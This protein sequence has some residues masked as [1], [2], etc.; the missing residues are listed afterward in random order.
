[1]NHPGHS[2]SL[3]DIIEW[4]RNMI[5]DKL[6]KDK[7][8][9]FKQV[10][11]TFW[12]CCQKLI[13]LK[14]WS[15]CLV[16][17]NV[18]PHLRQDIVWFW[19]YHTLYKTHDNVDKRTDNVDVVLI[20]KTSWPVWMFAWLNSSSV[21]TWF[22]EHNVLSCFCLRST[23]MFVYVQKDNLL[24]KWNKNDY[25]W[26]FYVFQFLGF[27]NFLIFLLFFSRHFMMFLDY[28][29]TFNEFF[30]IFSGLYNVFGI[31]SRHFLNVFVLFQDFIWFFVDF[32]WMILP[33]VSSK[34]RNMT[35]G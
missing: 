26:N 28:F 33:P 5:K 21:D 7:T 23:Q 12:S 1:M 25:F 11:Q 20:D 30:W 18:V 16:S 9:K 35:N 4:H 15:C 8:C 22:V 10:K 3:N 17:G 19:V 27:L 29:R 24:M 34:A 31:I 14:G 2:K 13:V 32:F 6:V